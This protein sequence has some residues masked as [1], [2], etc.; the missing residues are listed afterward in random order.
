M[1]ITGISDEAG[2]HICT[3]IEAHK[4]LGWNTL[5]LRNHNSVNPSTTKFNDEDFD[6][7]RKMIE[8]NNFKVTGFSSAIGNWSRSIRGD[9]DIDKEDL[10]VS[11]KRMKMLNV[12]YIRIMSWIPDKDDYAYTKKEVIRRSREL[13]KMAEDLDVILAHEN[14][15]GW[16]GETPE[17]MLELKNEVNSPNF[18]LLYDTGNVVA[19]GYDD[20]MKFFQ[21]LRG[22]I[23]YV[24]I[25]D[26]LIAKPGL[27]NE[28]RYVGEGEG[29]VREILDILINE[30][31]YDGIISIE[32]HVSAIAHLADKPMSENDL[33]ESYIKYGSMLN[34]MIA[35]IKK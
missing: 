26:S 35:S 22:N 28:F 4:K 1:I 12:R 5:E 20:P 15:T 33:F 32:P 2:K 29:R 18:V 27:E 14:C 9:F 7:V 6:Y 31:K 17:N 34:D 23:D 16:G 25:K 11:A 8:E 3:Q 30:D 19:H 24:H 13:A 10:K 21:G